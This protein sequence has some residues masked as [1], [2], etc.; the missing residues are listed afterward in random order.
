MKKLK[1]FDGVKR[2]IRKGKAKAIKFSPEIMITLGVS[3]LLVGTVV[4]CR[5]T[6]KLPELK[7]ERDDDLYEIVKAE[8]KAIKPD[9]A[10]EET[11][12]LD[13]NFSWEK[14]KIKARYYAFVVKE[15]APVVAID[16]LSVLAILK[17]TKI[18][19][20]RQASLCAA[21]AALDAGYRGYRERTRERFGDEVDKELQYGITKAETKE[22]VTDEDGKK[23]TVKKSID[24]VDEKNQY[25]PYAR[26]FDE[27]S[28]FWEKDAEYNRMF[29]QI[30]LRELNNRLRI[31]RF[32]FLNDVYDALGLPRSRAGQIVGWVYDEKNPNGDNYI[33]FGIFDVTKEG[34]VNFV[35]GYERSILLDF[36]VD[37]PIID[38]I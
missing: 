35:N 12:D 7:K 24:I 25:S 3:G 4:A 36:N 18:F 11:E 20:T 5:A 37:G 14:K 31:N 38:L 34:S 9:E 30:Q 26:F 1:I 16:A 29:L 15:Y 32:L 28:P 2:N 19:E 23:K 13:S 17:G 22:K 27:A 10:A 6:A 33:D 8:E 21:Y